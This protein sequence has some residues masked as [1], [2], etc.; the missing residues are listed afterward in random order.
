MLYTNEGLVRHVENALNLKTVYMWGGILRLVEKQYSLLQTIY[1]NE[2]GTGYTSDRWNRLHQMFGKNVYGVDCVGLIKSYLWSGKTE[3]GTGSP[4]YG[5][6]GYPPDIPAGSMYANAKVKGRIDTMP[7]TPGI[8]VISRKHGN[9]VGVYIGGGYTIESTL[10]SRGDGVVKHKLD[11]TFWTDWFECPYIE[12]KKEIPEDLVV[13]SYL[14]FNSVVRDKPTING[15]QID[16]LY[17]KQKVSYI[18]GSEIKDPE[19]KLIY[20]KLSEK[21]NGKDQWII[22]QAIHGGI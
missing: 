20:V 7:D 2:P 6:T 18:K 11:K 16:K 9:H 21:L 22:K 4:Y 19:S 15:T 14:D 8:I 17:P 1:G 13:S 3:G 10:G 12:Y 5:V